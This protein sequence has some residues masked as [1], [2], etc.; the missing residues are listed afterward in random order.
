MPQLLQSYCH[1][2]RGDFDSFDDICDGLTATSTNPGHDNCRLEPTLAQKLADDPNFEFESEDNNYSPNTGNP[3]LKEET[4]DTYTFGI[5]VSPEFLDGFNLAV[6]Y[7]DIAIVDAI[8]EIS[9]ENIMRECYDSEA[10]WGSDNEYC[11]DITRNDEGN[12]VK[13]LQREYNLD[14]LTARGYD[15]VATYKYDIGSYGNLSFKL[16]YNHIIENSQTYEGL[17]GS[18][19]TSQYAGYGRSKDKAA[20]SIVWKMDD[21]R[22]RLRTNYVGAF[23]ASQE[24]EK[25][26][27]EYV[28][29][30]DER[31]AA[32]D[33]GC[34]ANPEPLAYQNYGSF[35]KHSLS[36]SYTMALTDKSDL[37]VFG[38]INNVFDDKGAFYPSGRGNFY[39]GYGGG[40]GR[41][42]YLG[43]QYSF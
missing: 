13:I 36:A 28:A 37:R 32:G 4:A 29:A 6:D 40:A 27:L 16:D 5:T 18:S 3:N 33:A 42:V 12:I 8:D 23:K 41:Y 24:D 1:P 26:Y 34:I 17:D 35:L 9:N 25:D 15:V 22:I 21:L 39:S 11:N 31:C 19:V 10:A 7:Y 2:P 14:E 20:M 43:A 38:G 30:N